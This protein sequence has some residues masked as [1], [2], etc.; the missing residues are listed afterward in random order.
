MLALTL[1]V[2][3]CAAPDPGVSNNSNAGA[4]INAATPASSP[5]ST[6]GVSDADIIAKENAAWDAV[7]AKDAT[8][9]GALLADDFVYVTNEAVQE[10]AALLKSLQ[11]QDAPPDVTLSNFKVL[12]LDKDAAVITYDAVSKTTPKGQTAATTMNQRD[13]SAWLNRDGKWLLV[14]HQDCESKPAPP[15]SQPTPAGT[16]AAKPD[17][18]A[19]ASPVASPA[20]AAA[21]ATDMEKQVWDM[22]KANNVDGFAS[23]LTEDMLEVEQMGVLSKTES[24]DTVK[25]VDFKGITLSDFKEVKLDADATLV[26]YT[27]HGPAPD[28]TREGERHT[29]IWVNR[30][31]GGTAHWLAAFHHGGTTITAPKK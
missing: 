30:G 6:A 20:A 7:K 5:A 3:S 19:A 10:K 25:G 18:T 17:A 14:Y 4:N 22:L 16:A 8:A 15:S 27:V 31:S 29:S 12:K 11:E 13:S 23:L 24:V 28:F 1:V 21:T 26:T 2:S 9:M